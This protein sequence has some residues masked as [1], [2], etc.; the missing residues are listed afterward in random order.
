P[1]NLGVHETGARPNERAGRPPSP[2]K[3]EYIDLKA[4]RDGA[5]CSGKGDGPVD[6]G[7]DFVHLLPDPPPAGEKCPPDRAARCPPH[8]L[9]HPAAS[10]M[11]GLMIRE[12]RH[13]IV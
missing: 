1:H 8:R 13:R 10:P 6:E 4:L 3:R 7:P 2:S 5:P 9:P 11:M 12:A